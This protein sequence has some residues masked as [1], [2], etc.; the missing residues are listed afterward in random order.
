[1]SNSVVYINKEI[2]KS[3]EDYVG[4]SAQADAIVDAVNGGAK[5]I[6]VVAD[7]GCGKSSLVELV[8]Q[9][10]QFDKPITVN[11]W[12]SVGGVK[13]GINNE[14]N[15]TP[16]EKS[17]LYQIALHSNNKHLARHVNK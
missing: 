7:Y 1:M 9:K 12:D 17:L 5:M 15:L 8:S 2:Q 4:F 10:K 14:D 13:E 11:M 16:L 6:A 3:E